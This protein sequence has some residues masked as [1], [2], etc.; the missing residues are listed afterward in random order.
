MYFTS[1]PLDGNTSSFI[2]SLLLNRGLIQAVVSFCR[3][4]SVKDDGIQGLLKIFHLHLPTLPHHT[5]SQEMSPTA[6]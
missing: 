5:P 1:C 4:S 6:I 2:G 3:H